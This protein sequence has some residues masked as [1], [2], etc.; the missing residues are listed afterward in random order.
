M[1]SSDAIPA[2]AHDLSALGMFLA[3]DPVVQAIMIGLV[4]ASVTTWAIWIGKTLEIA[5]AR[6]RARRGLRLVAE[7]PDL[8]SALAGAGRLRGPVRALVEAA[9][10]EARASVGLA[11][12]GLKE[13]VASR[14]ERV[15]AGAS[16]RMGRGTGILATIGS[17]APFVGLFGTVWGIMNAFI[18]I[19]QAQTSNLAVVA[20]GIAEALLVTGAGL[21]AAIPAVLIYNV[22]ARATGAYRGQLL[23]AGAAVARLVS[24]DLDRAAA[25]ARPLHRFAAE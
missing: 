17:T 13:R 15:V 25:K 21:A 12:D 6:S 14:L 18:G 1:N 20:P 10:E 23:D 19:A 5:I 16:R 4:A 8:A 22:F 11:P 24:R 9:D 2:P 3:A 7:A